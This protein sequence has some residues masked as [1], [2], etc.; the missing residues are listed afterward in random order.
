MRMSDPR[1][2]LGTGSAYAILAQRARG[3]V[4]AAICRVHPNRAELA[5][6]IDRLDHESGAYVPVAAIR[7]EDLADAIMALSELREATPEAARA[8]GIE[9]LLARGSA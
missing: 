8:L 2:T 3:G 6:V 1:P 7:P 5:V 4:R 9:L